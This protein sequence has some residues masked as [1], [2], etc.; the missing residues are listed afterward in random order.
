MGTVERD[1]FGREG[2]CV[3]E[4]IFLIHLSGRN[5]SMVLC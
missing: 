3:V 2:Y 4:K 1:E 5:I